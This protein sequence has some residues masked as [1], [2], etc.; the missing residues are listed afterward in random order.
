MASSINH[1]E[2]ASELL[3]ALRGKRS[4]VAFSRRLGYRSNIASRWENG[5]CYPTAAETFAIARKL[6]VDVRDN[7]RAFFRSPRLWL[8]SVELDQ[9]RGLV[10]LLGEL[11]GAVSIVDLAAELAVSRFRVAR[12][13]HGDTQPKLPEFLALVDAMSLRLPEFVAVLVMPAQ[14]PSLSRELTRQ[15]A[16]RDA[17]FTRPWSH[18]VLRALELTDY[19]GLTSHTPGLLARKLGIS[20][21]EEALCLTL[22]SRAGQVRK[23]QGRYQPTRVEAVDLR[24]EVERLRELKAFWLERARERLLAGHDGVFGF[25]LFA[26]STH[27]LAVIRELYLRLYHEVSAI[28]ARSQPSE[29]VALW[30]TQLF[31]LDQE[32]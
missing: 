26:V 15:R 28:V 25:N 20:E 22:L 12:W 5:R 9:P 2:L 32:T 3:R 1:E 10:T 19:A 29:C 27:D 11:R 13:L 17:A 30:S 23:Q 18:A 7:L 6:R 24:S 14:L 4:Q 31:R 21:Q 16:A 8:E